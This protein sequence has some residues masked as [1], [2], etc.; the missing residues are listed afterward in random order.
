[1]SGIENGTATDRPDHHTTTAVATETTPETT[2]E[3]MIVTTAELMTETTIE[4]AEEITTTMTDEAATLA[5][6]RQCAAKALLLAN[7]LR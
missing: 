3:A 5:V 2:T 1:M 4:T 7:P 6:S